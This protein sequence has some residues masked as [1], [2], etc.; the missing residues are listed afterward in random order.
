MDSLLLSCRALSSPTTCRF[1]PAL[2]GLPT[3]WELSRV[4]VVVEL[5][6]GP[7]RSATNDGHYLASIANCFGRAQK[8][9]I[10]QR[11]PLPLVRS[12]Q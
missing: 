6:W 10:R 5:M 1:I 12:P 9:I 3:N 8:L 2:S 4:R 7:N 11:F